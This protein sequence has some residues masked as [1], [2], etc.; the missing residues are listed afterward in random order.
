MSRYLVN[1]RFRV[2]LFIWGA[3]LGS[4]AFAATSELITYSPSQSGGSDEHVR[5]LS[6][7]TALPWAALG[8]GTTDPAGLFHIQLAQLGDASFRDTSLP[9]TNLETQ[10]EVA[11]DREIRKD[12]WQ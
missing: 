7:D 9:L 4:G 11:P 8:I 12:A 5:N 2:G 3:L 10:D 1:V 6:D